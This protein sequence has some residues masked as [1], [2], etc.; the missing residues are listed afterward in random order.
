MSSGREARSSDTSTPPQLDDPFE[1]V[2]ISGLDESDYTEESYA[3]DSGRFNAI[4]EV[5]EEEL[6]AR[7]VLSSFGVLKWAGA[8]TAQGSI[9][10]GGA[11]FPAGVT[12]L[13]SGL[14]RRDD[15]L[16][17]QNSQDFV[18]WADRLLVAGRSNSKVVFRLDISGSMTLANWGGIPEIAA[19]QLRQRQ[20]A[21]GFVSASVKYAGTED[22]V[23]WLTEEAQIFLSELPPPP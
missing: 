18:D 1:L 21:G 8:G 19:A 12:S 23:A 5:L 9:T 10:P 14:A 17:L 16:I 15:G 3:I 4:Q 20:S 6:R 11:G 7:N 2:V 22:W 13:A